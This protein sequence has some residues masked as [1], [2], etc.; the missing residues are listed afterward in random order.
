MDWLEL[1]PEGLFCVPGA[2]YIDPLQPVAHAVITH[3]HSDHARPGHRHVTATPETLAIMRLRMGEDRAG[4]TQQ[5]LAYGEVV[6]IGDIKLW[7][8]PAGHVLGS[9]QIVMEYRGE[10]A[11]VSGDYKRAPDPTCVPFEVVPC[12]LF[13]TEATF[14]LPVF[15]LPDPAHEIAKLLHDVRLFPERTHVV[16][17][18]AL[19]KCQRLIALLRGGGYHAPLWLHGALLP[20]CSLYEDFGIPL[21]ELRSATAAKKGEMLGG[22]VLAPPSAIADRWAR[23]LQDP[24][25]CLASGWMHVRQRARARGV[26]LPVVISD[27]ADWDALLETCQATGAKEIWVTH[28]REDAL[29]H[30]LGRMQIRGRALRLIGYEDDEEATEQEVAGQDASV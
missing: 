12:D 19:G 21:G 22:I 23:R 16:G 9:A 10:R 25:V 3:G 26:E 20:M 24:V 11:V 18:Y 15:R 4:Q 1:K 30:A 2:F 29:I 5:R 28:G 8:A 14:G 7:L 17:C 13:V 6:S 27:H